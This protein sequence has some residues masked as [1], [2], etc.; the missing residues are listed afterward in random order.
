[1]IELIEFDGHAAA[2]AELLVA[3]HGIGPSYI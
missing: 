1:M 2:S 3:L